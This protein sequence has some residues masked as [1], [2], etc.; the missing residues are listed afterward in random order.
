MGIVYFL[1][2]IEMKYCFMENNISRNEDFVKVQ[3]I[4]FISFDFK[5]VAKKDAL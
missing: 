4:Y 2:G 5:N 1:L 3:G